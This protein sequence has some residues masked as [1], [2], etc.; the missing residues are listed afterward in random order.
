MI[1]NILLGFLNYSPMTGY[2]LKQNIDDSTAHFWH[3]H[4]SQI[5][6]SLREME[7]EGLVTSE[8]SREEGQPDRRVYTITENGKQALST[9]LNQPMTEMSAIKDEFLVRIFFSARR[10]PQK[11]VNELILQ[12]E[13]HLKQ[14]DLY[15]NHIDPTIKEEHI[16][17]GLEHDAAFWRLTLQMGIRYEQAYLDWI[18]ESIQMMDNR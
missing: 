1:K 6:T 7:K 14:L 12:R 11:V 9:W 4:H 5:Y 3:A 8:Y 10:D 15:L 18:N 17:M 13:L 2:D 16:Q